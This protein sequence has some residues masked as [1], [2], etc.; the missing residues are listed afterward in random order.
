MAFVSSTPKAT[1]SNGRYCWNLQMI[2]AGKSKTVRLTTR[3]L[4]GASG[5]RTNTA[6]VIG[7]GAANHSDAARV[8]VLA[9]GVRGGG[10]TG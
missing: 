6:T 7:R 3:I 4:R 9:A 5:S 1:R 2:G 10:V 8:M